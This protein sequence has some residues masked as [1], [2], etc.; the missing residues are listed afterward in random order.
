LE[1]RPLISFVRKSVLTAGSGVGD[2]FWNIRKRWINGTHIRVSAKRLP[3]YLGEFECRW[4][5]RD[6][7]HLMLDRLMYSF[8]R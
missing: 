4:N 5:V 2:G 6:V 8:I 3:K 7:R 1:L